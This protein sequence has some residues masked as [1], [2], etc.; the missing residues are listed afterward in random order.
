VCTTGPRCIASCQ[1]LPNG[2][3]QSCNGCHFYIVCHYGSLKA[4][5]PCS[6]AGYYWDDNLKKCEIQSGTCKVCPGEE[7]TTTSAV[8]TDPT[9][10][11]TTRI[12]T[13]GPTCITSCTYDLPDGYYQLCKDC[14]VYAKCSFGKQLTIECDYD[15]RLFWDDRQKSC[16][17]N[18]TTCRLCQNDEPT[19]TSAVTTDPAT[20]KTTTA[21]TS[22]PTCITSCTY[23]LP[24]GYYQLCKGCDVY[25][26]CSNGELACELSCG[27]EEQLFWDDNEK[28]CV[29]HSTTCQ[30]CPNEEATTTTTL[31][32]VTDDRKPTTTS[33]VCPT[34]SQHVSSCCNTGDDSSCYNKLFYFIC[35][36]ISHL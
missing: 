34:E 25:A 1:G 2:A 6:P 10:N 15:K 33:E 28:C 24:D 14:R 3:Y 26:N 11:R 31:L 35:K 21:C 27:Y 12:C 7:T 29:S 13:S 17:P 20:T 22:G 30:S 19:T 23:G 36:I 32:T 18:S 5:P 9:T 8:T 16:V 4:E